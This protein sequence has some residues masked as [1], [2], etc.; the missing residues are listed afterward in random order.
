MENNNSFIAERVG[1][2]ADV[3]VKDVGTFEG[4]RRVKRGDFSTSGHLLARA[5]ERTSNSHSMFQTHPSTAER[6]HGYTRKPPAAISTG[7]RTFALGLDY[8]AGD[9]MRGEFNVSPLKWASKNKTHDGR[10]AGGR[11]A[12]TIDGADR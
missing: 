4:N 7:L 9:R 2:N 8:L 1:L 6:R 11:A 3:R 5:I 10:R 12:R